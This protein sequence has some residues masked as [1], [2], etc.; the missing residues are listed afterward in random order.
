M[1]EIA[2]I[3]REHLCA[4][5]EIE[6]LCFFEPWSVESLQILTRDGGIGFVVLV[7]GVVSAY[8]GMLCVLDEG[9]I[10]NIATHPD[11]RRRGL[12]RAVVNAL[13]EYAQKNG[14]TGIFLE[15]RE[16][17]SAAR[18]LYAECGFE[19]IGSRKRF[20]RAPVEDAVLMRLSIA[21]RSEADT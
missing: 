17:N 13:A 4:V 16:S 18:S 12:G 5:A 7:D 1:T 11:F 6:K 10:T 19:E 20:Y 9:Q 2:V 15:V 14:I 21:Q 8:G 3:C